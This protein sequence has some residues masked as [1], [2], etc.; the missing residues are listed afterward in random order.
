MSL[1]GEIPQEIGR[2]YVQVLVGCAEKAI[3]RFRRTFE[4]GDAPEKLTF[5]S[6]TGKS[7]SFDVMGIYSH[8]LRGKEVFIESKGH[9]DGNK[10]LDGYKEFLAKAYIT[11]VLYSRHSSDL[12][13]YLTNVPFGSSLG[14]KLTSTEYISAVL[15]DSNNKAVTEI[16]GATPLDIHYI[17][18]LSDRVSVCILTDSFV[19][20]VGI[21]YPVKRGESL[22]SIIRVLHAGNIPGST[23]F[24][25]AETIASLNNLDDPNH[26]LAGS[27][28]HIPWY[29]IQ[30]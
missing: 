28:L 29:G 1:P 4:V 8:P 22:W 5:S 21:S 2:A 13:W 17:H 6:P 7:F 24:P 20:A 10:V 23:Y 9:S 30:W 12:F 14:K 3:E 15:R 25:I 27:R 19:K 16:M 18:S 26:I 11:S